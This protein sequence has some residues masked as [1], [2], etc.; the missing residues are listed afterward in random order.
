MALNYL[1]CFPHLLLFYSHRNKKIIQA[2]TRRW[3]QIMNLK[4][5]QPNGFIYLLGYFKEFR[6]LFYNRIGFTAHFLNLL[7]HELSSLRIITKNIGEGLFISHGIGTSISAKSIGKNCWI[8]HQV[9]IGYYKGFPTILDNVI[10]YTG[11]VIIGNITIG[12]NSSIGAN[13]T[14]LYDVPDNCTVYA[15]QSTIMKWNNKNTLKDISDEFNQLN[16]H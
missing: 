15:A 3:L 11:A 12:N 14:V 16:K 2:D 5:N 6:N 7:C 13:A 10:I 1:R 4:Y 8:G 9:S